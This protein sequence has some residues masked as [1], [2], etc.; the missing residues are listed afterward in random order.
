ML[1]N[2]F[3]GF[4]GF[5][6]GIAFIVWLFNQFQEWFAYTFPKLNENINIFIGAIAFWV[7]ATVFFGLFGFLFILLLYMVLAINQIY[8]A[9]INFIKQLFK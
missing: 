6:F 7:L 4:I 3:L 2:L 9:F 8:Y 5:M 1:I